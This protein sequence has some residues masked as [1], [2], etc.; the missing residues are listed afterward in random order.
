MKV[1]HVN[2]YDISGGAAIAANR[3]HNELRNKGIDSRCFVRKK[4]TTDNY[5]YSPQGTIT[6]IRNK[7]NIQI[8]QMVK[9]VIA[10]KKIESLSIGF[11]PD[12]NLKYIK[13]NNP[14]LV[15]LHWINGGFLNIA[16]IAKINKLLIWTFHDMWPACGTEHYLENSYRYKEGF[17]QDIVQH[18][19]SIFD[20]NRF[21]YKKKI[22]HW[23]N[24]KNLVIVCPSK[25]LSNKIKESFVF[26][27]KRIETIYN[28][29]DLDFFKPL[30]KS[31]IRKSLKLSVNKKIILFGI[32]NNVN[33]VRKGSDFL[34]EIFK[35]LST[36]YNPQNIEI[37]I[38]GGYNKKINISG[39][40]VIYLGNLANPE[41]LVKYY[42]LSDIFLLP[43]REDN[44][45]NTAIESIA[46]GTP[47]IGFD[48]GGVS[49]IISHG[50]NGYLIEP[51]NTNAFALSI[52][53]ILEMDNKEYLNLSKNSRSTAKDKFDIKIMANKYVQ[54]YHEI[55]KLNNYD[56]K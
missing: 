33:N 47:V 36:I 25:W 16:T 21:I 32:A 22:K 34:L 44:L 4:I 12:T 54:L 49:E 11:L 39:Y 7:L 52:K 56:G 27:D 17:Q 8:E 10:N 50:Y 40:D 24:I 37:L 6:D 2:F 15:H 13:K 20:I 26:K 55:I 29:I 48:V 51:F 42:A 46:C 31:S 9:R 45:P 19:Y 5:I 3:L 35:I 38:F 18:K 41:E 23:K 43:S 1:L 30:N 14:D 28:G 53:K